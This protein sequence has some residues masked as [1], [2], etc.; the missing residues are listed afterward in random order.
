MADKL[1]E[2]LKKKALS[3]YV[4]DAEANELKLYLAWL[5]L[6]PEEQSALDNRE[7]S[8]GMS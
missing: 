1:P 4:T 8:N 5:R 2:H 3:L 6:T 7:K